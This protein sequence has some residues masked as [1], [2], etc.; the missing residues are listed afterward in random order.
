VVDRNDLR[1]GVRRATHAEIVALYKQPHSI[2]RI[3]ALTG[4]TAS[5]VHRVLTQRHVRMRPPGSAK[6]KG[7]DSAAARQRAVQIRHMYDRDRGTLPP[8]SFDAIGKKL[9]ISGE[10]VRQIYY[11]SG[12]RGRAN[13]G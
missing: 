10:R 12:G 1:R 7:R 3:A 11:A 4:E 2:S 13:R 5:H 8:L 9:G 6:R